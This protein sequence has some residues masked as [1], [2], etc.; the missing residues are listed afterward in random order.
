MGKNRVEI[1][2]VA[3][4]ISI[5]LVVFG[6]L[7]L[8][9][10]TEFNFSLSLFRMPL[11]FFLS[12]VFFSAQLGA[13]D[14]I[15]K[16]ADQLLKPY[17]VTSLAMLCIYMLVEGVDFLFGL[18]NVFY[19]NRD[20]IRWLPMW[21]LTHL[22]LVFVGAYLLYRVLNLDQRSI[23]IKWSLVLFL[24][25]VGKLIVD[26]MQPNTFAFSVLG[27]P[28]K[29]SGLPFMADSLAL[30]L[31]FFMAGRFMQQTIMAFKPQLAFLAVAFCIFLAIAILTEA[32]IDIGGAEFDYPVFAT[33]AAVCGLY[34][35]L[36]ISYYLV[37]APFL[38]R[39]FI[40]MGRGSLFILIFH[41]FIQFKVYYFFKAQMPEE[42]A[43]IAAFIALIAS[44]VLPLII[45]RICQLHRF[46][47][48][49]YFPVYQSRLLKS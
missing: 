14:Y 39:V 26:L 40:T 35:V 4:G 10:T 49:F 36:A 48:M 16:K 38:A 1:V 3:K 45:R 17:L 22:W 24:I 32:W 43:P 44:I 2:D 9:R 33:I 29:S 46:I 47:A 21:Y 25:V 7:E 34:M 5:F 15:I 42:F 19:G 23:L 8:T 28:V 6:H 20:T 11:F 18:L 41:F 27:R 13:K 31:G 30:S 37:K 12:G